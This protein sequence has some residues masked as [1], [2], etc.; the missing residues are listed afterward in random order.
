[1]LVKT[2]ANA[3]KQLLEDDKTSAGAQIC[4]LIVEAMKIEE[5]QYVHCKSPQTFA[6]SGSVE[7]P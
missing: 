1:M 4:G 5:Q 3:H 2:K 7:L 6:D